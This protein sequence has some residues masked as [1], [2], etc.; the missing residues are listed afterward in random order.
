M[1]GKGDDRSSLLESSSASAVFKAEA[2]PLI[3][4]WL[5]AGNSVAAS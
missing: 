4:G 5:V 1:I 2:K 3:G